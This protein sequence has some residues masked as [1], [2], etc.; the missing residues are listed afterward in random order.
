MPK[1]MD[2]QRIN[3]YLTHTHYMKAN[4]DDTSGGLPNILKRQKK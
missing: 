1:L 3:N 2:Y 4:S